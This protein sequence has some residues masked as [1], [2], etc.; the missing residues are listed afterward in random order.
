MP[1]RERESVPADP[2]A[3]LAAVT[4]LLVVDAHRAD[5]ASLD[6]PANDRC[7]RPGPG[8]GS[9]PY[10]VDHQLRLVPVRYASPLGSHTPAADPARPARPATA[11]PC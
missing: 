10:L 7:G 9:T 1:L 11:S 8:T 5:H 3:A 6:A 2:A 4:V